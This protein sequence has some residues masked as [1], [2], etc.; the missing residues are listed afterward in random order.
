[1]S[2][3]QL[4]TRNVGD[5][6]GRYYLPAYQRGYRWGKV[7]IERMLDDLY[8]NGT[9]PYCLQPIVVKK[10][11]D[12]YELIDGQQ[13]LTTIFLIYKYFNNVL[14]GRLY[15]PKFSLEY[16]T[17]KK[18]EEFLERIDKESIDDQT[19]RTENIDYYHI[20]NAYE[21]ICK[22]F[23]KGDDPD[24]VEPSVLTKLNE[25]FK[26]NVRLIWY[27]V[28]SS[29]DGIELFERLN[30]GK[31]PLTS[32]ELV[33]ALFLRDE[34]S[35]EM[36]G[37]QE[38]ISLQWDVMEHA[39]RDSSLWAFL[40]KPKTDNYSTRIDLILDLI[41][42]KSAKSNDAY[43]T[44][45][46]F[47]KE[48]KDG[49][50]KKESDVL[51]SIWNKI[52]RVYLTL[53][54]WHSD[55]EF[56]HKIGYLINSGSNSLSDIYKLWKGTGEEPLAKDIF[57]KELDRLIVKSINISGKKELSELTYSDHK[58]G[59]LL[60]LFNVETER[61]K[62]EGKRFFPF[63]KHR[64]GNWSLEHIHAQHSENLKNNKLVNKWLTDHL[65]TLESGLLSG[66]ESLGNEIRSFKEDLDANPETA[67]VRERFKDIQ[68]KTIEFF[69]RKEGREGKEEYRDC[70][71]NLALLDSAQNAALS[72]Y[73][74]D[75]K[76]DII[77][78]YDKEGRYIPFCTKMV[79]FKYYSP[80]SASLHYWGE[81]DRKAY[82][83]AINDVISPYYFD[84]N[85]SES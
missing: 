19:L 56:Y 80:A 63:D 73:V 39:L 3:I 78:S 46:Y 38:E 51:L 17:R 22:Y 47:D 54:E 34:A 6:R 33:K 30:I 2:N 24:D 72:N 52:Y 27:E 64:E 26:D 14:G 11:N 20:A 13:R 5:L 18:S 60:F 23:Q 32:S 58:T 29:E 10:V 28:D 68:A 4:E 53:R 9:K 15:R 61:R 45:F 62:D 76:R 8:E 77:I 74:F 55:H 35:D 12:R 41:S 82:L 81:E 66:W 71:A 44:F 69:T 37:R 70:I 85:K 75:V 1:M 49:Y 67:N 36:S 50:Q 25:W 40:T 31:I 7:E 48:I 84:D 21:V 59:R 16:E 83:N 43:H 65:H 57:H 79:F 42:D